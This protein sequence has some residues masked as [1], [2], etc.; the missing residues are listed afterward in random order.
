MSTVLGVNGAKKFEK[1]SARNN[2]L[3]LINDKH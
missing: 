1:I 3:R 2:L